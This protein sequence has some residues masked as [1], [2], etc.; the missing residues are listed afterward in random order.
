M[1]RPLTLERGTVQIGGGR[2]RTKQ[3][4]RTDLH[5]SCAQCHGRRHAAGIGNPASGDHRNIQR[6]HH[7]RQQRKSTHL[8]A[9]VSGQKVP[10]MT[11]RFQPLRNHRISA[12][13]L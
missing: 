7:L 9:Q 10:T 11:A 13:R 2:F 12:L 1:L 5:T 3:I 8:Q 6:R 4:S